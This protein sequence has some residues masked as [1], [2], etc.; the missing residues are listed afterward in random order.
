MHS[1]APEEEAKKWAERISETFA[2][3]DLITTYVGPVI[4]THTG[5]ETVAVVIIPTSEM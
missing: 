5:P 1:E 4:R 2:V 3:R